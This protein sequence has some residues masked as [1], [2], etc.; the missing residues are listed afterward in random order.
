MQ[1][2]Q[3]EVTRDHDEQGLKRTIKRVERRF[4]GRFARFLRWVR[5]PGSRY[6]RIPL[7]LLLVAG[8]VFSFVPVL[9]IWMLPLGLVLLALDLPFLRRPMRRLLVCSERRWRKHQWNKKRRREAA[10]RGTD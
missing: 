6:V 1:T 8:G 4:P 3:D 9:G 7:A 5:Q 10:E 2:E